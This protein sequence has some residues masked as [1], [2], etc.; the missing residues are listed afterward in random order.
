MEEIPN[1][2]SR[3]AIDYKSN[4]PI[5]TRCEVAVRLKPLGSGK[6]DIIFEHE[7]FGSMRFWGA[8]A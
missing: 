1:V 2:P 7:K 8:N 4:D 5:P 3:E 6:S